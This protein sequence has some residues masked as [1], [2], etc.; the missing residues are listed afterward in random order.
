MKLVNKINNWLNGNIKIYLLKSSSYRNK[1]DLCKKIYDPNVQ[2]LQYLED[3]DK[4]FLFN[5]CI[6]IYI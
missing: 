3:T 2:K 5:V 6:F 4:L 1:C